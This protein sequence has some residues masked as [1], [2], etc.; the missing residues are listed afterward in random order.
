MEGEHSIN[1]KWKV[2]SLSN[3]NFVESAFTCLK[4]STSMLRGIRSGMVNIIELLNV[5][6][7]N[8]DTF[9]IMNQNHSS[10]NIVT[11]AC[12][13]KVIS[14]STSAVEPMHK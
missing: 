3:V 10:V 2:L 7:Q 6:N 1:I 9:S 4:D 8:L 13:Q 14:H 12:H 5:M 11:F